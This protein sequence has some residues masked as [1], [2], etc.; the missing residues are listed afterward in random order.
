MPPMESALPPGVT[1]APM[2][3]APPP[4]VTEDNSASAPAGM[5]RMTALTLAVAV[6]FGTFV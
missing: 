5:A 4:G 6:L 1:E 2:E 3:I